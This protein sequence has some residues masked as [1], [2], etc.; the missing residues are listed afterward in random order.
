MW[1]VQYHVDVNP[2]I[3]FFLLSGTGPE[4][5]R[6]EKTAPSKRQRCSCPKKKFIEHEKPGSM[7]HP[8]ILTSH[9]L[10]SKVLRGKMLHDNFTFPVMNDREPERRYKCLEE[11]KPGPRAESQAHT[12]KDQ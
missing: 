12:G 5:S 10:S 9:L 1:V 2:A 7:W 8:K 4:P 3:Y 11:F 6:A